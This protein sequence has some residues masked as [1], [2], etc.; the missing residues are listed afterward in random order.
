MR[1]GFLFIQF[2]LK[3]IYNKKL[4]YRQLSLVLKTYYGHFFE[5]LQSYLDNGFC[6]E[7]KIISILGHL[8]LLLRLRK[9]ISV[10]VPF[11]T[12]FSLCSCD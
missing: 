4:S 6:G 2:L 5:C 10:S 7:H 11:L 3:K 9:F 1:R 8:H 12:R